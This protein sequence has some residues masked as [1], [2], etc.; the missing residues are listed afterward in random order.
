[1]LCQVASF[2]MYVLRKTLIATVGGL[3]AVKQFWMD[4]VDSSR[5]PIAIL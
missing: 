2:R 3:F 4:M 5:S 1:M